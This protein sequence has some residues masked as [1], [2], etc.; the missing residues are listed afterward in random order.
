MI[1]KKS[2]F[3]S[4]DPKSHLTPCAKKNFIR[5]L[6][7]FGCNIEVSDYWADKEEVNREYNLDLKNDINYDDYEAVVLAVAH[8]KFK[9]IKLDNDSQ[10]V[11]DI[12]SILDDSD[13][14]L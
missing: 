14:R 4:P 8:D 5:E 7:D 2:V 3:S 13:G 1:L 10:V 6:Q 9:E 11:F 12:K